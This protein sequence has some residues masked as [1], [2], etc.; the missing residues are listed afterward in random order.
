MTPYFEDVSK[1]VE[2]RNRRRG[3]LDKS[4]QES[5]AGFSV[6]FYVGLILGLVIAI[7]TILFFSPAI[8]QNPLFMLLILIT[9]SVVAWWRIN[10]SAK[11]SRV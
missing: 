6:R 3:Y 7:S 11:R 9:L 10:R 4:N 8:D 2:E 1:K 5:T